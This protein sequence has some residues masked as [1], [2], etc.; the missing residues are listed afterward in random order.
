MATAE[1]VREK[2]TKINELI[3]EL[4]NKELLLSEAQSQL[5]A[6]SRERRGCLLDWQDRVFGAAGSAR[7][8]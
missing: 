3:E 7:H 2:E 1:A 8:G 5:A 4:G 6:V